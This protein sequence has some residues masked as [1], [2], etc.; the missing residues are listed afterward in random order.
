MAE[1]ELTSV[2][3][4]FFYAFLFLAAR[5]HADDQ[6]TFSLDLSPSLVT[7]ALGTP[8]DRHHERGHVRVLFFVRRLQ[9]QHPVQT[10]D[11]TTCFIFVFVSFQHTL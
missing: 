4:L 5:V 7:L 3:S 8:S 1:R 2:G 9:L 11:R 10:N 6:T